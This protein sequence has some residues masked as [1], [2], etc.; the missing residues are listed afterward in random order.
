MFDEQVSTYFWP[1]SVSPFSYNS[2]IMIL[3][4]NGTKKT[5]KM[6]KKN[7]ISSVF[8]NREKVKFAGHLIE[9]MKWQRLC[10][11]ALFTHFPLFL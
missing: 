1:C 7:A 9:N 4:K 5:K 8:H 2:V 6:Q 11:I 3:Q 10:V